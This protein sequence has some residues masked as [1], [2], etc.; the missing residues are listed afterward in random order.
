M[1]EQL[2]AYVYTALPVSASTAS[3]LPKCKRS[4][5]GYFF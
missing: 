2:G 3:I 5:D 4:K 1:Q